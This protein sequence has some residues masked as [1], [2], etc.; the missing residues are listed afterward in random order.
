MSMCTPDSDGLHGRLRLEW[1][2]GS[3]TGTHP[4]RADTG[5]DAIGPLTG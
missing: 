4:P 5:H 1:P 3:A 2:V